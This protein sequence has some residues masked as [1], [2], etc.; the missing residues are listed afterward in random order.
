[1]TIL[2]KGRIISNLGINCPLGVVDY[3]NSFVIHCNN[4]LDFIHIWCNA[5]NLVTINNCVTLSKFYSVAA[6]IR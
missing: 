1:M 6:Y 4:K 2:G 3:N 5:S